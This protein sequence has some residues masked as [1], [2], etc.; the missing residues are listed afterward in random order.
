MSLFI[1]ARRCLPGIDETPVEKALP[2]CI[3]LNNNNLVAILT[4]SLISIKVKCF[5]EK[6]ANVT[7]RKLNAV[8]VDY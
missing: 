7:L 8:N 5:I 2:P 3:C 4:N 6:S 1:K